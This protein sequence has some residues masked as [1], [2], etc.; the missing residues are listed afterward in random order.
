M[1][2]KMWGILQSKK[3]QFSAFEKREILQAFSI[4]FQFHA[5]ST[6]HMYIL[7]DFLCV[8]HELI[9]WKLQ[10]LISEHLNMG[11][12]NLWNSLPRNTISQDIV[13]KWK[14]SRRALWHSRLGITLGYIRFLP[15][16]TKRLHTKHLE[17][18]KYPNDSSCDCSKIRSE[19]VLLIM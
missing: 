14:P 16:L 7:P 12:I 10:K 5:L 1:V 9:C 3:Y 19:T 6:Y 18:S 13:K 4:S 15:W 11:A 2:C 8:K 17:Y